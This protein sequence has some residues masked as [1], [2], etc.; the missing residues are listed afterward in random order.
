LRDKDLRTVCNEAQSFSRREPALFIGGVIAAGFL[1]SR[2]LRSSSHHS[3]SQQASSSDT[4]SNRA[5]GSPVQGSSV[6]QNPPYSQPSSLTEGPSY[7]Q[8]GIDQPG[9]GGR[10]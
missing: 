10:I 1:A 6:P 4:P 2:F 9:N 8:A 5:P 7:G 3:S